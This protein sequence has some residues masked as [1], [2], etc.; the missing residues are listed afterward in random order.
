[1]EFKKIVK[2]LGF[3]MYPILLFLWNVII[4]LLGFYDSFPWLDIPM[5]FLGGIAVGYSFFLTLNYLQ[6]REN[7]QNKK[8]Y[9]AVFGIALVSLIAVFWEFYEFGMDYFFGLNY[10]LSVAD[11][12]LDFFLGILGGAFVNMILF[13]K[14]D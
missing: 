1:M 14:G 2:I 11:T 12:M 8:I 5:H 4:T 13:L 6:E 7:F 10:Q 9:T 3:F